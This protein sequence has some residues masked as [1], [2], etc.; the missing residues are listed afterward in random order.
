MITMDNLH[1][2]HVI[3]MIWDTQFDKQTCLLDMKH[4]V[5]K[6]RAFSKCSGNWLNFITQ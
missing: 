6:L 1:H 2:E 3:L 4:A 5:T